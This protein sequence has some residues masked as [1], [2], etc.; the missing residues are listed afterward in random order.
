MKKKAEEPLESQSEDDSAASEY[1]DALCTTPSSGMCHISYSRVKLIYTR[2]ITQPRMVCVIP[3]TINVVVLILTLNMH[4]R[5]DGP[6][7]LQIV[8]M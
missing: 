2:P 7:K 5:T 8:P 4:C 6:C 1:H 3:Y